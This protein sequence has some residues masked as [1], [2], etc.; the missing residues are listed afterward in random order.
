M[1]AEALSPEPVRT[2]TVVSPG[3]IAPLAWSRLS[4]AAAAAAVGST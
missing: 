1:A 3:R 2:S 4:P